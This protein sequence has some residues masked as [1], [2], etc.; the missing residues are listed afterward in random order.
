MVHSYIIIGLE[1]IGGLAQ[2]PDGKVTC[3]FPNCGKTLSCI[4]SA[5]RHYKLYHQF[6]QPSTCPVCKKEFK[7]K[8]YRGDHM[9]RIHNLSAYAMNNAFKPPTTY[10][11]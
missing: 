1:E 6:N 7:N 5:N 2:L 8:M 10:A 11:Q 9:R 4:T 3:L